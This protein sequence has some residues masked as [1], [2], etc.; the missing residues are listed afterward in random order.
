ML[1]W[2]YGPGWAFGPWLGLIWL[3]LW[4]AVIVFLVRRRRGWWQGGRSGED[5]LAERYAR[6]EITEQE[7]RQRRA[8][9]RERQQ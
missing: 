6:G 5:V 8:V 2:W 7:Y 4:A 3:G 9:L 1:S